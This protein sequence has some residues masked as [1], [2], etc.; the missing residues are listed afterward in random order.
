MRQRRPIGTKATMLEPVSAK[1]DAVPPAPRHASSCGLQPRERIARGVQP[2]YELCLVLREATT[3]D[4]LLPSRTAPS[5]ADGDLVAL[6]G[7]ASGGRH[8]P[9]PIE[10]LA[11][12]GQGRSG[13]LEMGFELA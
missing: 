7:R 11:Q 12:L 3:G 2:P 6:R 9:R 10:T 8:V 1:A 5:E 4:Q 13:P